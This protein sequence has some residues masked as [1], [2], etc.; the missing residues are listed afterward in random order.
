MT[1]VVVSGPDPNNLASHLADHGA[2][3]VT[4]DGLA[5]GAKLADA[6]IDS[7]DVFVLTDLAQASA[8]PVALDRN[9]ELQVIT[10][11]TDSLPEFASAQ[12]DLAIDPSLLDPG[13]VAEELLR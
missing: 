12:T 3:T 11:D 6:G 9:P 2:E 13:L 5:T 1:S 8:I 10:Y 4:V 7:A